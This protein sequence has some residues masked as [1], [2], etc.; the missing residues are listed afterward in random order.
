MSED[1]LDVISTAL[2]Q[3]GDASSGLE[4]NGLGAMPSIF[5]TT[6][7]AAACVGAAGIGVS[8]LAGAAAGSMAPPVSVDRR[9]ASFWFDKSIRERGW[10]VPPLWDVVAGDYEARD[11]WIR[12]HTNAPH[13]RA[14]ALKVL[15]VSADRAEV[16]KA[17]AGWDIAAL[18]DAVVAAGGCA[19]AMRSIAAWQAHEQGRAIAAE[20]LVHLQF[21]DCN[22]KP[23]WPLDPARPLAGI[24]VLD[25]TRIL[26][27]P[28][29]TRFLAGFGARVLR[30]DP[31]GWEE[32][33]TI[34]E[35]AV[36]KRCARLNLKVPDGLE[37]LKQL[38]S[39]AD[40][41]VHGYRSDALESL[42]AGAAERRALNPGLVDVSL[43]AYGWSGPWRARRG[44]DSLVQMSSGLAEAG[45]AATGG[46]K[47][48]PLPVQALDHGTGYMM[49]AAVL[50]GLYERV[51]TGRALSARFSLARTASLLAQYP[52]ADGLANNLR[53]ET[54][55]DLSPVIEE[56]AWGEAQR[57]AP[58]LEI[59]GAPMYWDL[60]AGHLGRHEP[61][62]D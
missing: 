57:L 33:G 8:A 42:G 55:A 60:P 21:S 7:F 13:H 54:E 24:K 17:V 53:P 2:G 5:R 11:G 6:D 19:A 30:I 28:V 27:G 44:F 43:D 12:L 26:A 15:G 3:A 46:Q 16:T 35:V 62:W 40:V 4:F 18:E 52:A 31:E 29:S 49:A 51:K 58:P 34:P 38:V 41:M 32:P 22:T 1:I 37:R 47:P 20:P 10:A 25:L 48:H 39:E 45:M 9:L 61:A 14:A 23:A 36:G 59:G 50:R 56:T